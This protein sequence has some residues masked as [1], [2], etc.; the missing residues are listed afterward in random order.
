MQVRI[1]LPSPDPNPPF[2][3]LSTLCSLVAVVEGLH[4][5]TMFQA[6]LLQHCFHTTTLPR[7]LTLHLLKQDPPHP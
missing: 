6:T 7:D 1:T 2:H 3:N 5:H 4:D